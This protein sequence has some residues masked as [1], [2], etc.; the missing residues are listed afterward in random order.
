MGKDDFVPG[1]MTRR[2]ARSSRARPPAATVIALP[3]VLDTT[4]DLLSTGDGLPAASHPGDL[5]PPARPRPCIGTNSLGL[6]SLP[7]RLRRAV[8]PMWGDRLHVENVDPIGRESTHRGKHTYADTIPDRARRD[9][10]VDVLLLASLPRRRG[11]SPTR[12]ARESPSPTAWVGSSEENQ[13]LSHAVEVA[14]TRTLIGSRLMGYQMGGLAMGY[15]LTSRTPAAI[16]RRAPNS[17]RLRV[18]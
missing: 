11:H 16:N 3:L 8:Q 9:E 14:R 5:G 18:A 2:T 1:R 10:R 17:I 12:C 15:I 4:A 6:L 13:D 7:S